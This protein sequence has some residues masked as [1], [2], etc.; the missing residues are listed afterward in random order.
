[1]PSPADSERLAREV[2]DIYARA[3]L[4]LL[5]L[6]RRQLDAG[7]DRPDWAERRLAYV[8]RI[9]REAQAIVD[10]VESQVP[11][12]VRAAITESY[13][14]G[15]NAAAGEL[16]AAGALAPV[17][18]NPKVVEALVR[19]TTGNL[20]EAHFGIVRQTADT[21]RDAVVAEV[22]EALASSGATRL[23]ASQRVVDRLASA[24]YRGFTDAAGRTWSLDAYAEMAVR[25]TTAQATIQ[26]AVDRYAAAGRDLVY[27]SDSPEECGLCR[28]WEGRVLSIGGG[29][30][31]HPSLAEATDAGLFHASCTHRVNLYTEGLTRLPTDTA[32]AQGYEDRQQQRYLERGLREWKRRQAVASTPLAKAKAT[33]KVRE[34]SQKIDAHTKATGR[35]RQRQ[36][37]TVSKTATK[38]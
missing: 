13:R 9:K 25:S 17:Y 22:E 1:V 31:Q 4:R 3:E 2:A 34:W 32:N 27:V 7:K 28:P 20:I 8:R 36:R 10:G 23:T 6:I 33:A 26:G 37:E 29:S 38:E 24:G 14:I 30:S 11:D 18:S 5:E 16:T 35:Q 12:A 19:A 15:S 21:F